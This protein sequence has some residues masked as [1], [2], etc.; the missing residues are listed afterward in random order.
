MITWVGIGMPQ[1]SPGQHGSLSPYSVPH[2]AFSLSLTGPR[3]PVLRFYPQSCDVTEGL[4][5]LAF[6]LLG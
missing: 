6:Y 2:R 3:S 1:F 4:F 5:A